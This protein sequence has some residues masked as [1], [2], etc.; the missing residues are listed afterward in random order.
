VSYPSPHPAVRIPEVS[1]PEFVLEHAAQWG[2]RDALVDGRSGR[3]LSYAELARGVSAVAGNMHRR[4]LRPG[5]VVGLYCPNVPEYALAFHGI[6]AAGG[7]CTTANPL[8]TAAELR[9]QLANAGAR[10]LVTTPELLERAGLAASDASVEEIFVVGEAPGAT[11][12]EVLTGDVPGEVAVDLDPGSAVAALPYSSGTTGWPKGVVLTHRNL[13]ANVCQVEP[14]HH[15]GADDTVIGILPFFHIYGMTVVMNL[16]L[17]GGATIV[18]L[19]RFDLEEFLRTLSERRVTCAHLVPP[20]I[21]ALAKH[22]MVDDYDLDGLG[23]IMSGAAPLGP[24]LA[25]ACARRLGCNVIQGYGLTE[26]SPVT[27]LTPDAGPNKPGS[28]GPPLPNTEC[29]VVDPATR[30]EVAPG[31]TGEIW[32]R[33]PQVMQGYLGDA[34]ATAATLEEG[35]LRTGDLG[36]AD[37]DAYFTVVDRLKELIK[38]KGYQVAPA[39]LEALLVT[40]PD[41]TDAAVVPSPD[42]EAGEVPVAYIVPAGDVTAESIMD[43]VAQRVAAHKKIRRVELVDSIPKSPSGKIL[44]R[45][46][47]ERERAGR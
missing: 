42:E 23:M 39:E 40:H 12:F 9:R 24:D 32:V 7:A 41:V 4:G 35:W 8:L 36:R 2:E 20:I 34:R 17:R 30:R 14:V 25:E 31:E 27:H 37:G 3:A 33:G 47:V 28:I 46:L 5:D 22:P 43:Y 16:A 13:V 11:P 29:M 19:P 26:S 18:T 10:Y 21:L 44:R 15:V 38:Y 6:A 45:V 1:L